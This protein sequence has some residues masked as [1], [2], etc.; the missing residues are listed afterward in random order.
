MYLG[1]FNQNQTVRK[2]FT[3]V[4]GNGTPAT[5]G[6]GTVVV[7]K[8][9]GTTEFTTN[10]TLTT[11]FDSRPGLHLVTV[12]MAGNITVYASGS[13]FEAVLSVGDCN[14]TSIANS[15]LFSWSVNNRAGSTAA[16]LLTITNANTSAST[17][18]THAGNANTTALSI[19]TTVVAAN[20]TLGTVNTNS[21][22]ANTTIAAAN[23]T[24]NTVN[25]NAA[26]ANT[27]ITAANTTINTANTHAS[28]AN[29][30][31]TNTNTTINGA[32]G[33][34]AG[35]SF[36]SSQRLIMASTSGLLDG[37]GTGTITLTDHSG[38]V[39][40]MSVTADGGGNRTAIT[41]NTSY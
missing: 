17:A 28:N 20:T 38:N 36:K 6:N 2:T 30:S 11:D 18:A 8:N 26:A 9:G 19:N 33:I 37:A 3:T 1:D 15:S 35:V 12:D 29:T 21:A 22:N 10:V 40:V 5:M 39:T 27:T 14:G 25:T 4:N 34:E 31:A 16:D 7:Y 23:T 32:N 24:L 41:Y 13:E